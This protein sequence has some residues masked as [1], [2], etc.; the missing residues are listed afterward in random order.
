MD[1]PADYITVGII[2]RNEEHTIA[3]TIRHLARQEY[4][5]GLIE[6]VIVDGN[7][8]DKTREIAKQALEE[9]KLTYTIINE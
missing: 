5:H 7:S 6:I 3:H 9:A 8:T 1:R 4:P 2:A